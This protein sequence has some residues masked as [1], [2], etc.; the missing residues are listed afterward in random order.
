[1]VL[2]LITSAAW[3][4]C[5]LFWGNCKTLYYSLIWFPDWMGMR[6]YTVASSMSSTL[7]SR[8]LLREK[9]FAPLFRKA[10]GFY[11][12]FSTWIVQNS[13]DNADVHLPLVQGCL[14]L[15]IDS[16]TQRYNSTCTHSTNLWSAFH[17]S[18]QQGRALE[19]AFVALNSMGTH[20]HAYGN[21]PEASEI[22]M[23]L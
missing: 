21:T 23:P 14:P 8:K 20:C 17:T 18:V 5:A 1:M 9:T 16:T 15:L 6:L 2:Q 4:H 11:G 19:R 10:N 12:P 22:R 7:Y 3:R 13:L